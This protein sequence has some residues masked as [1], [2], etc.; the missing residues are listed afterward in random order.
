MADYNLSVTAATLNTAITQ[1]ANAAPQSTTY[2][3]TQTDNLLNAKQNTLPSGLLAEIVN[4]GAKNRLNPLDACGY[5]SQDS[6][7]PITVG[8]VTYTLNSDGSI[9]TTGT[10]TAARALRIPI[11]LPA[12]SYYFTGCPQN[13]SSSSYRIDLREPGTDT[14]ITRTTDEGQGVYLELGSATSMDVCLRIAADYDSDGTVFHPMVC[15]AA[16]YVTSDAFVKYCP[17]MSELYAMI[18][19]T[20]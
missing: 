18:L 16:D 5:S 4:G 11:T 13:G 19:A 14:F 8:D 1:A 12:G 3:K 6:A 9:S 17:S 15:T 20:Q 10:P 7:F 2:T